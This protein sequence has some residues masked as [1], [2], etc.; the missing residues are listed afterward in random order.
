MDQAEKVRENRLRQVAQRR[1]YTLS[2]S[3]RRDP[4]AVDY[5]KWRLSTASID[6]LLT[7]GTELDSLD[8]VE[9]FL[10]G[11][12]RPLPRATEGST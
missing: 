8:D 12:L 11:D 10:D 4:L 5:G 2:K 9:A 6:G 7:G 3:R 1:G